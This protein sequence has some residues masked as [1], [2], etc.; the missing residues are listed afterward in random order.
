MKTVRKWGQGPYSLAVI[1][2]GPGAPGEM[3]P[4]ARELSA[5]KGVLEPFQTATTLDGQVQELR[6]TIEEEAQVPVTLAGFSWGAL[7]AWMTAARF[8]ALVRKLILIASPPFEESYAGS[9]TRTRLDR[10]NAKD[11][12]EA[13][14]LLR[15]MDDEAIPAKDPILA[16]LGILL[17]RA[18]AYDPAPFED[19]AFHVQY[20][21]FREVWDEAADLRRRG[22]LTG[23]G[24]AIRCPVIAIHGDFDPHPADGVREPLLRACEDFRFVLLK[25]CGHRPWIERHA[26]EAFFGALARE[27]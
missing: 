1:H 24:R 26:S 22:V 12:A 21:V 5:L 15:R 8:P 11:R 4:V 13:K 7:L 17:T 14:D 27:I 16:R 25:K 2:G 3:A 18:D 9:I 20:A 6:A 23:M 19:E 10:M